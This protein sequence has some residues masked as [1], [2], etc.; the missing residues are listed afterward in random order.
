[1]A[2]AFQTHVGRCNDYRLHCRALVLFPK[3]WKQIGRLLPLEFIWRPNEGF[4]HWIE[5][6]QL[7]KTTKLTKSNR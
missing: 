2:L 3:G 4:R 7:E 1:M 5:S 6:L